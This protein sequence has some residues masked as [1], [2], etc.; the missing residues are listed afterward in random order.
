M[1][2]AKRQ[3]WSVKRFLVGN[4]LATHDLPHQAISRVVGLAVFAS[5]AIS[6]T[7]YATEE[8]FVI[9]AMA[10]LGYFNIS[11]PLAIAI[12][13]L[14]LIV[15]LSYRQTIHAYPNGG[16]SYIVSRDNLGTW[17][18]LVAAAALL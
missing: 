7:A 2:T 4:P 10:G 14:L 11:I 6:S 5:D 13:V 3:G 8:I 15:T 1:A 9:L 18:A 16:G 12:A 17:A